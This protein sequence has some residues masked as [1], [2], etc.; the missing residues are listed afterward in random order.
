V[1]KWD[2]FAFRL[3][4]NHQPHTYRS[5]PGSLAMLAAMRLASSLVSRWLAER[6]AVAICPEWGHKRKCATCA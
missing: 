5:S 4:S 3:S 1:E 2:N 6:C